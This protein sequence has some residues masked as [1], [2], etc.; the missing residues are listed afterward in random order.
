MEG[1]ALAFLGAGLSIGLAAL[2]TG[3]GMGFL[4]G[5]SVEGIARQPEAIDKIR[6]TMIIGIA[7]I[8]ALALYALV[9]SFLLVF[10]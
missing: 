8:E 6:T 10:K 1:I 4:V 2:G 5:K 3:I 9:I 7:F